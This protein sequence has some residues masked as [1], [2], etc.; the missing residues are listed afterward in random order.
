M[1]APLTRRLSLALPIL[2]YVLGLVAL[3]LHLPTGDRAMLVVALLAGLVGV[4]IGV[5]L[6]MHQRVEL[7]RLSSHG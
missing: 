4:G 5:A 6:V 3:R 7:G 1:P 2:F